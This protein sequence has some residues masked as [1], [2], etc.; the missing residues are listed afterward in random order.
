[1]DYNRLLPKRS[2][3]QWLAEQL[4]EVDVLLPSFPNSD[5]AVFEEWKILFEKLIPFFDDDVSIV[6]HSLGAMFLAKYLQEYPLNKKVHQL[7]LVAGGYDDDSSEDL[8]SFSLSS[9]DRLFE[10]AETIHLFHSKDDPVVSYTELAKFQRDLPSAIVH[11]FDD[12]GH[13]LDPTFPELL[14]TINQK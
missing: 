9:A 5:N 11:S 3:K 4:P 2:W 8:G 10:S 14:A 13:F 7:I 1:M 6:G 12:M